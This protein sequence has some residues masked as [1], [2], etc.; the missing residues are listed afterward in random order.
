M[1]LQSVGRRSRQ[2]ESQLLDL[3]AKAAK[4]IEKNHSVF[5]TTGSG[6]LADSGFVPLRG[7]RGMWREHP[8]LKRQGVTFDDV[9]R[10]DYF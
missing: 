2:S 4:A 6:M 9:V 1:S 5:V 8:I 7:T 3:A 10:E